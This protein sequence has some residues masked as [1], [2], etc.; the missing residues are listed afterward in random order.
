VGATINLTQ[1]LDAVA[2]HAASAMGASWRHSLNRTLE[3][4]E[5]HAS[6]AL[7]DDNGLVVVISANIATGHSRPPSSSTVNVALRMMFPQIKS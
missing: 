5:G 3:A 4:V 1:A 2:D 6:V 7:R